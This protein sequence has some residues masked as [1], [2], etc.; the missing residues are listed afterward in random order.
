MK[1][2]G[3]FYHKVYGIDN[4]K[5]A[6][7]KASKGKRKRSEVLY[8]ERNLDYYLY[9]V[10]RM[11]KDKSYKTSEYKIFTIVDKGKTREIADLPFYP[12]RIIHWAIMLQIKSLLVKTFVT[13]TYAAIKGRG[14][15]SAYTRLLSDVKSNKNLKYCLKID[16]EKFFPNI[17]K[18]IL[19]TLFRK[20]IKDKNALWLLDEIVDGYKLDGI[21]IGN[22]TSQFF[23]NFYLTYFDHYLIEYLKVAICHRYMDDIVILAKSKSQ[24]W[25]ILG[26]IRSYLKNK[27]NINV[28]G[29][30]QI[31]PIDIRGVDFVG[32]R[33][34]RNKIILRNKTRN[35]MIRKTNKIIKK[36]YLNKHDKGV[37]SSYNGIVKLVTGHKLHKNHIQPIEE[38]IYLDKYC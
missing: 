1:R 11:L 33:F 31:F 25:L 15:K 17:N 24:L 3:N 14:Q 6:F 13:N 23:G 22:Y 38:L 29:N 7:K 32:Y 26:Y 34:Y 5:L 2:L 19:K 21:P 37:Y 12:D 35:R 30:Y 16:V 20:K 28:K 10:Q 4:L 9:E 27:L 18:D 36:G 8:I